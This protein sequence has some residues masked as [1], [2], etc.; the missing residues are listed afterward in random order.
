LVDSVSVALIIS[1]LIILIGFLGNCFF[2]KTGLPDMLFLISLG[3]L[4]GPILGVFD[5]ASVK[6]FAPYVAALALAYILFDGGIGLNIKKVLYNSPKALLLAGLGFV[7]SLLGV[8]AFTVFVFNVPLLYGL[9]FGSIFG[10]SSS[11]VVI[12]LAS[13]IKIS[14]KG[15]TILILESA[16]TDIL[17]IVISLSIID[18]IVTGNANFAAIGLGIAGKFLIGLIMGLVLGFAWLFALKKVATQSFSYMLTLGIVLLG[19]AASESLGGSGALTVL[20][21]G[22]ILGNEKEVLK[23]FK[24]GND[25][26]NHNGK[27][28][29]AVS[30]GLK[31]FE[32]EIAFLIRTFFF[33]FLGII[34]SI[35][36][37]SFL[38][39]G[40]LLA[41]I[42]L[43]TRFGAVYLTTMKSPLQKERKIMTVVLTRGLAAAVLS[44]LPAQ[45]GLEYSSLFVDIAVVIIVSTAIIATVGSMILSRQH[46]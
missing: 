7:F 26:N 31:R 25:L 16:I 8:A 35:S 10:G 37:I 20:L 22:L 27:I 2:K 42:L 12:S 28:Y 38:I 34:V 33:V 44:T 19:Y 6:N 41:L 13:K 43:L 24:Q 46:S 23:F 9:L 40:I 30:K 3:V 45:Y 32:A 4:F 18:V 36:S 14:E 39:S 29:C 21:F 11:V 15:S 5:P 17:C 1:A